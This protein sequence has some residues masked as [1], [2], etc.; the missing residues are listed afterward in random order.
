M[1]REEIANQ[2][3]MR[4]KTQESS[5]NLDQT[6]RHIQ[7]SKPDSIYELEPSSRKEQGA[8]PSPAIEE[9]GEKGRSHLLWC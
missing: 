6:E 7:N 4:T 1:L 9:R 8:K 5:G 2:L 3:E